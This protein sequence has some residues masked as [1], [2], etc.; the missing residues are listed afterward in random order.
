MYSDLETQT[1]YTKRV[2][3]HVIHLHVRREN[4]TLFE[5]QCSEISS[6][7]RSANVSERRQR[8]STGG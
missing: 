8:D 3:I 6:V 4:P 7:L 1:Y 5:R 2:L